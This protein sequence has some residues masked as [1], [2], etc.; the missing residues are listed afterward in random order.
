MPPYYYQLGHLLMQDSV[1]IFYHADRL[2][3]RQSFACTASIRD[4]LGIYA[5]LDSEN[6]Q[7]TTGKNGKVDPYMSLP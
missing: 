7:L 6:E 5:G 2:C 4:G 3:L 1:W